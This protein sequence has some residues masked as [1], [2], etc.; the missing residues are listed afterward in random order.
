[1]EALVPGKTEASRRYLPEIIAKAGI[2]SATWLAK[3]P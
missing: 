2:H 1:M 3:G